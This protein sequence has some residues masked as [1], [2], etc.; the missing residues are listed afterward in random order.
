[1]ANRL[2]NNRNNDRV[3]SLAL[4]SLWTVTS[5]IKLKDTCSLEEKLC[6]PRQHIVK[7][8]KH[9]FTDRDPYS[10]SHGLPVV[11]YTCESGHKEC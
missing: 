9:H 6:K 2:G 10:Q 3:F 8:Q 1:M 5:A 7:K 11:I 4:K